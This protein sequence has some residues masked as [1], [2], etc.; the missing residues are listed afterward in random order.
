M[1]RCYCCNDVPGF[2]D[3]QLGLTHVWHTL[4]YICCVSF[5]G[6]MNFGLQ[7]LDSGKYQEVVLEARWNDT[8]RRE[9]SKMPNHDILLLTGPQVLPLEPGI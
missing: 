1:S 6:A 2:C 7:I 8:L 4:Q 5:V 9:L 3:T